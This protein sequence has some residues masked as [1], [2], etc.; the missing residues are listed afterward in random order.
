MKDPLT[1]LNKT[2]GNLNEKIKII[3]SKYRAATPIIKNTT[4]F[5]SVGGQNGQLLINTM[6]NKSY[7]WADNDWR[8]IASW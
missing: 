2:I 8:Q 3:E 7:I 5:P 6:D 4:G 1:V